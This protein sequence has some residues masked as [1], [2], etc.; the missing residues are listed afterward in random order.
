[1]AYLIR[2][3]KFDFKKALNFVKGQ[4]PQACPNEG[5]LAQLK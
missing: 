2:E 5:F 3:Q 1:M 4:R